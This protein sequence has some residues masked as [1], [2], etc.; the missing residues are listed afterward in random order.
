MMKITVAINLH[1]LRKDSVLP[2]EREPTG[3]FKVGDFFFFF[4]ETKR[5]DSCGMITRDY[6]I[7]MPFLLLHNTAMLLLYHQTEARR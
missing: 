6:C 1:F 5:C 7:F 3:R 2:R 4:L